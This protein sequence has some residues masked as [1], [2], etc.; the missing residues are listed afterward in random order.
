MNYAVIS[1]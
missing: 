1:Q